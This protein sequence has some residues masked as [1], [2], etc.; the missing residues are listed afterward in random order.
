MQIEVNTDRHIDGSAELTQRIE[1]TVSSELDRFSERVT[2]V[3]VH[4]TDVNADKGGRDIECMMEARPS[5]LDPVAVDALANDVQRAVKGA[6]G[7]LERA[8]DTRF[9]KEDRR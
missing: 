9:G 2:R 7:K 5:G 1:E 8:L 4:L 3:I 6:V